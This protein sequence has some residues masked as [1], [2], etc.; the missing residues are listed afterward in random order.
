MALPSGT[1]SAHNNNFKN[2]KTIFMLTKI[3][4]KSFSLNGAQKHASFDIMFSLF[5][6][7]LIHYTVCLLFDLCFAHFSIKIDF[8]I[9]FNAPFNVFASAT[10]NA[11][12]HTILRAKLRGKQEQTRPWLCA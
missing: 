12:A 8:F 4:Y 10:T 6:F 9:N 2:L 5:C 3:E 7:L 1:L 11:L